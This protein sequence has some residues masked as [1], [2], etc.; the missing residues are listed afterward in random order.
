MNTTAAIAALVALELMASARMMIERYP[1]A[2][3][4]RGGPLGAIGHFGVG[5]AHCAR[6]E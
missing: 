1:E 5:S 4:G 2:K 6:Q 3:V